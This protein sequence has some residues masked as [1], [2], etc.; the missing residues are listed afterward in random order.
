MSAPLYDYKGYALIIKRFLCKRHGYNERK[1]YTRSYCTM[2]PAWD[3]K[4][5][6]CC[7]L[8]MSKTLSGKGDTR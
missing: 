3:G 6:E 2:C 8:R 7:L 5:E 1:M 4:N